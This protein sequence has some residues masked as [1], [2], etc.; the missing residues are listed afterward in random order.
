[1]THIQ[2]RYEPLTNF[3][4]KCNGSYNAQTLVYRH[5]AL[6]FLKLHAILLSTSSIGHQWQ[7]RL[8]QVSLCNFPVALRSSLAL[9]TNC[10]FKTTPFVSL[11]FEFASPPSSTLNVRCDHRSVSIAPYKWTATARMQVHVRIITSN[12]FFTLI[13]SFIFT[14]VVSSFTRFTDT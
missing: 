4:T 14:S 1:M 2:A 13:T 3:S 9:S 10:Q 6:C 12:H 7:D 11:L 8:S 5:P